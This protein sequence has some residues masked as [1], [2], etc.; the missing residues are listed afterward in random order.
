MWG[1]KM[2]NQEFLEQLNE[3]D[4]LLYF[5][6]LEINEIVKDKIDFLMFLELLELSFLSLKIDLPNTCLGFWPI[7][8]ATLI[9]YW[10]FSTVHKQVYISLSL[11]AQKTHNFYLITRKQL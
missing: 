6:Q 2:D 4:D 9:P 1:N 3:E 8:N 7:L 10:D 5:T 11:L